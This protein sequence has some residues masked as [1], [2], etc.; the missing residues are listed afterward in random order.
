[1]ALRCLNEQ[2]SARV[3]AQLQHERVTVAMRRLA[4][5]DSMADCRSSY[6]AIE[7]SSE[8]AVATNASERRIAA[9]KRLQPAD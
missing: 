8:G 6:C 7:Q 4:H 9:R 1:M 3:H 2:M 5:A